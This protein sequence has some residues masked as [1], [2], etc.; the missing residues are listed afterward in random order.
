MNKITVEHKGKTV[1]IANERE[2]DMLLAEIV[3]E[4]TAAGMDFAGAWGKAEHDSPALF[5]GLR[6][7]KI[8]MPRQ[9]KSATFKNTA[10]ATAAP[11]FG[12]DLKGLFLLPATADQ[13]TCAAAWDA[14]GGQKQNFN[15]PKIFDALVAFL[16]KR[17][18]ALNAATAQA[19]TQFPALWRVTDSIRAAHGMA[20]Y[21]RQ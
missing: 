16:Q 19:Q 1:T 9:E 7:P 13:D 17:G 15:Y 12:S 21:E 20:A 10:Q 2:R 11:Q 6:H 14:N 8:V 4:N 3:N 18:V 5:A